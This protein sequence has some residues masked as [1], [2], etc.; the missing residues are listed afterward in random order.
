[1]RP[2]AA[3]VAAYSRILD[4]LALW[5]ARPPVAVIPQRARRG[6]STIARRGQWIPFRVK[7]NRRVRRVIVRAELARVAP[8]AIG[9]TWKTILY[10]LFVADRRVAVETIDGRVC[11]EFRKNILHVDPLKR[12]R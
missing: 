10:R 6:A 5:A 11:V 3:S 2:H 7:F 4:I 1:M 12:R 9:T 8:H